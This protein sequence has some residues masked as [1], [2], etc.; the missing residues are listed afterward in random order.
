MMRF[1]RSK[2]HFF[3]LSPGARDLMNAGM[4]YVRLFML[5]RVPSSVIALSKLYDLNDPRLSQINVKGDLIVPRSDRIMTR[6]RARQSRSL[7]SFSPLTLRLLH[8]MSPCFAFLKGTIFCF[9]F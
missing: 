9:F 3:P 4:R 1:G 8:S 7:S 6:S 5:T 2:S